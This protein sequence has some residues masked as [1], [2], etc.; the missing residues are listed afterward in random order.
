MR[1]IKISIIILVVLVLVSLGLNVYL[2]SQL[3]RFQQQTQTLARELNPVLTETLGN[4]VSGLEEI[5]NSTVEFNASID[6]DF[7]VDLE[8]PINESIDVPINTVVPIKQDI[9]TTVMMSLFEGGLE[10]PVDVTVPVDVEVPIDTVVAIQVDQSIP[11]STTVPIKAEV[12]IE[13]VVGET[14]L[15]GYIDELTT[16]LSNFAETVDQF[17]QELY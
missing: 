3:L 6:T 1:G 9:E 4:T 16:A 13:I 14:E 17:L 7:P 8:I 5:K 15:A 11:I 10:V 12:P 2:I